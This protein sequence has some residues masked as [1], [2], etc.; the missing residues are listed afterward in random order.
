MTK[1]PEMVRWTLEWN[2][3]Q[4]V[5]PNDQP[6]V[7]LEQILPRGEEPTEINK[8]HELGSPYGVHFRT[9]S[10]KPPR[11]L[12]IEAKQGI[13]RKAAARRIQK[14]APLFAASLIAETM[15]KQPEYFGTGE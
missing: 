5:P 12:S 2:N 9:I 8:R 6:R 13:R 4:T 11:Q 1:P 10:A 15:S 14:A 3:P 7:L